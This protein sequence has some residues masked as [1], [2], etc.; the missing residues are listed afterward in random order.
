MLAL[1]NLDIQV[2]FHALTQ[3]KPLVNIWCI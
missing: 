3:Q 2:D 1:N